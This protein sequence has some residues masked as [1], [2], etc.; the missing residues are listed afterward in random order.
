M[1]LV[2]K[3]IPLSILKFAP[4]IPLVNVPT[5]EPFPFVIT[6]FDIVIPLP[7]ILLVKSVAVLLDVK[8]A[9]EKPV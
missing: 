8:V 9:W 1:L 3:H 4:A 2:V 7:N 6:A 5:W